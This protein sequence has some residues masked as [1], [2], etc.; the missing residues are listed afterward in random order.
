M[1]DGEN[2]RPRLGECADAF[3]RARGHGVDDVSNVPKRC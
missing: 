1:R 3:D 2:S